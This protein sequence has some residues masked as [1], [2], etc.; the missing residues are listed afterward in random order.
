MSAWGTKAHFMKTGLAPVLQ[1]HHNSENANE[2]ESCT[3]CLKDLAFEAP[4]SSSSSAPLSEA[5]KIF[6]DAVLAGTKELLEWVNPDE[7]R[8]MYHH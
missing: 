5:E 3:I 4:P 7:P 2:P 6:L 1:H 8:M